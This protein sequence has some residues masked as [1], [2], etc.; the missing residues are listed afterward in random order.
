VEFDGRK[1][2][3]VEMNGHR[4]SLVRIERIVPEQETHEERV[5]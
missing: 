3:I 5:V 4:I 2:T 1:L